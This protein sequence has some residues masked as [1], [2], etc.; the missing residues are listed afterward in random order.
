M[1]SCWGESQGSVDVCL[2]VHDGGILSC[3]GEAQERLLVRP[4]RGVC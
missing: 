2:C 1:F 3:W 4:G